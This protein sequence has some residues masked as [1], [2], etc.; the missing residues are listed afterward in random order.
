MPGTLATKAQHRAVMS[1]LE[2]VGT[3]PVVTASGLLPLNKWI[4][5]FDNDLDPTG[6]SRVG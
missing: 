1:P 4:P 5:C 2:G 3:Q 6:Y